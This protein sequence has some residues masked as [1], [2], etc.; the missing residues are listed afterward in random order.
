[1]FASEPGCGAKQPP[2][3]PAAHAGLVAIVAAIPEEFDAIAK[4]V[5]EGLRLRAGYDDRGLLMKGR[6]VGAAVLLAMTGDGEARAERGVSFLL[7]E[8][9]VSL[10]VGLGAAG[11][12]DSSLRAGEILVASRVVDEA[13]EAPAPDVA[14]IA[15]AVALG[16]KPATFVTVARPITSSRE[17]SEVARRFGGADTTAVVDMESAAWARAATSRGVPYAILRAVSDTFDEELPAFL[18]S[19]MAADGSVGRAAVARRLV[20]HPSAL[21]QLLRVRRRVRDGAGALG[22]FLER[23]LPEKI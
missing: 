20:L 5:S 12:L 23:L 4:F 18:S 11:A 13:G 1:M 19:C 17:K 22:L 8:F 9:P 16:A 21:P 2:R 15:R 10:L 3:P 14:L 7:G 6:M